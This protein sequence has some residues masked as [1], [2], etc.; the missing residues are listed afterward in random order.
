MKRI[1]FP[2]LLILSLPLVFQSTATEILKLRVFDTFVKEQVSSDNF[3][4]LN[5]T[6]EDLEREGGWPIPRERLSQIHIE[7]LNK[8]AIGVGWV[9]SFPQPDRLGG[10]LIFQS[11]FYLEHQMVMFLLLVLRF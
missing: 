5:I 10:D 2:L 3:V 7:L 11:H 1:I 6:E 4:I 8:G 9:V